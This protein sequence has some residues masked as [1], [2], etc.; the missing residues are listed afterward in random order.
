MT[1]FK[2]HVLYAE[3]CYVEIMLN[4]EQIRD[5]VRRVV[6]YLNL[7]FRYS[8]QK[9]EENQGISSRP[10]AIRLRFEPGTN[11]IQA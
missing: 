10:L 3:E 11:Q 8:S 1:L 7:V 4:G 2:L 5:L 9:T 6:A